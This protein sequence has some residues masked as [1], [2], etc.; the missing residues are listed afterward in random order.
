MRCVALAQAWSAAGGNAVFVVAELPAGL[1]IH[2]RAEGFCFVPIAGRAERL[3]DAAATIRIARDLHAIWVV[4]DGEAFGVE[5]L[6]ALYES[7]LCVLLVD[8]FAARVSFPA[9][10]VLNPNVGASEEAYRRKGSSAPLLLG[11]S[12]TPLRREFISFNR[13]R[14]FPGLAR[15]VLVTLGGSDPENLTPRIVETLCTLDGL[16]VIAVAGAGYE[17][18]SELE[19]LAA[20]NVTLISNASNMSQLMHSSDLAITAAGGTLWE[21]LYSRCPVISYT[22][23]PVQARVVDW[24][25][26]RGAA[27]DL[28]DTKDFAAAAL[29]RAVEELAAN[30]TLRQQMADVGRLLIDGRGPERVIAAIRR[31]S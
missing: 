30:R 26:K 9:H 6:Q 10:V 24:V 23:N 25:A 5:Y 21:L 14:V 3:D 12:H 1:Q 28:G 15:R 17:H 7:G 16:H 8:D 29:S 31:M 11:A 13:D 18:L 4:V 27:R 19:S 20:P 2:L 22:R